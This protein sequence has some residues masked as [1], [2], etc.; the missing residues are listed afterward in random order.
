MHSSLELIYS[1]EVNELG[2][3]SFL[4]KKDSIPLIISILKFSVFIHIIIIAYI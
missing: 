1:S 4:A 3:L 2:N